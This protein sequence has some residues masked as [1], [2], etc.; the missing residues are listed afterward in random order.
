MNVTEECITRELRVS[1]VKRRTYFELQQNTGH[2]ASF[3]RLDP[4]VQKLQRKDQGAYSLSLLLLSR[5][6]PVDEKREK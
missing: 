4:L 2:M 6:H 3:E 1:K 5:K